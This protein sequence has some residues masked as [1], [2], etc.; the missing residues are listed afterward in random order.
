MGNKF[1]KPAAQNGA[2]KLNGDVIS[3]HFERLTAAKTYILP[4]F[5]IEKMHKTFEYY[6]IDA[7][8]ILSSSC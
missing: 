3:Y 1:Q 8:H 5:T 7:K 2:T 6:T 4:S